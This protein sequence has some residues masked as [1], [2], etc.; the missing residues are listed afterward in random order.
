MSRNWKN[1]FVRQKH[2]GEIVSKI[3]NSE[4]GLSFGK[5]L[6]DTGLSRPVLSQHLRYLTSPRSIIVKK[7]RIVLE[8]VLIQVGTGR[9]TR[10]KLNPEE[11]ET[12]REQ[13]GLI[14]VYALP[15]KKKSRA[16]AEKY[17]R[18]TLH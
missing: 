6:K 14:M 17:L 13:G 12:I 4:E 8:P 2:V 3:Y 16:K 15:E 1:E 7:Q 9:S 5:L 11:A 10:Y 18:E